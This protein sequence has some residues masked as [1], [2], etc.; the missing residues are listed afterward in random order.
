MIVVGGDFS[1]D[2]I[3]ANN[4]FYTNDRGKTWIAPVTPPHGYRSCVEY[5]S[6]KKVITCGLTGV[7]YSAD[8]GKGW[9]S[10]SS[11]GFHVCRKAKDGSAVFL[12]GGNGK[13]G[14]VKR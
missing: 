2:T 9:T 4:C 3:S 6:K 10:I 13:I 11:E 12:A 7:D 5:I 8:G 1:R 14:R